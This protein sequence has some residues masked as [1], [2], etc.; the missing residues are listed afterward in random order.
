VLTT[1]YSFCAKTGCSDGGYPFA[2]LTLSSDG[3]LY[4]TTTYA[5]ANGGGTIFSLTTAGELTTLHSFCS[6]A[7]CADG[8]TVYS[9]LLKANSGVFYGAALNGGAQG[10]GTIFSITATG[11]FTVVH[12]FA[13]TDGSSPWGGLVQAKNGY[14]YGTT[15]G[16]GKEDGGTVFQIAGGTKFTTIYNFCAKT[17]CTDGSGP[18]GTLVQGSNGDLFGTTDGG[19][20]KGWGTIF[21]ISTAGALKTLHS[22]V[23]TA[24]ASLYAGLMQD[25]NG[26]FYG[27]TYQGGDMNCSVVPPD[28]CGTVFSLKP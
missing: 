13:N 26:T 14:L 1:I 4:G 10:W 22:F 3:I 16:G 21:Q 15:V 20:V 23:R 9:A 5:G 18:L 19:G 8:D 27:T 17:Y 28:G 24:G 6:E 2:G 7:Q 12:T 25:S 11:K